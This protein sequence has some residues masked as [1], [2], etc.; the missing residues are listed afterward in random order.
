MTI[1]PT[2]SS[3]MVF[4]Q[5]SYI[6]K[7]R[8]KNVYV[9]LQLI[10]FVVWTHGN[11]QLRCI[12]TLEHFM[13]WK[14]PWN[15]ILFWNFR[16][17]FENYIK[18]WAFWKKVS[19]INSYLCA[20][21]FCSESVKNNHFSLFIFKYLNESVHRSHNFDIFYKSIPKYFSESLIFSKTFWGRP[22]GAVLAL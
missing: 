18:F 21:P 15:V 14:Y 9:Y 13:I 22:L 3:H 2:I 1:W 5:N 7:E 17:N 12:I 19:P 4:K 10:N 6:S 20:I 8:P 11:D 16:H